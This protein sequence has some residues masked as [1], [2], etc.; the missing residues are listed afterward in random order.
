M[1]HVTV[2]FA[3]ERHAELDGAARGSHPRT[4][5]SRSYTLD[6]ATPP[7]QWTVENLSHLL[8][9]MTGIAGNLGAGRWFECD[10]TISSSGISIVVFLSS[11]RRGPRLWSEPLPIP[12]TVFHEWARRNIMPPASARVH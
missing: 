11:D 8:Q 1:V 5:E 10:R 12:P 2:F 7:E 9:T 6:V 4:Q 3:R